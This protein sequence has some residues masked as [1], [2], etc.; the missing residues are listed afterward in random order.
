M[1]DSSTCDSNFEKLS[2]RKYLIGP[3]TFMHLFGF[4][5]FSATAT[6]YYPYNVGKSLFSNSSTENG[7]SSVCSSNLNASETEHSK[8]IQSEVAM[9]LM[10]LAVCEG[11]PCI[12]SNLLLGSISDR[13]GRKKMLI[14][15]TIGLLFAEV[16]MII[17][18][19]FEFKLYY[20]LIPLILH[21]F[22][23]EAFAN[24][25]FAL[26]YTSDITGNNKKR[27]VAMGFMEIFIGM[28]LLVGGVVA[29]YVIRDGGYLW[30]MIT[31]FPITLSNIILICLLPETRKRKIKEPWHCM[32]VLRSLHK[33]LQFYYSKNY[34]GMR[35]KYNICIS[36]CVIG[37]MT[38]IGRNQTEVLYIISPPFCLS[39]VNVG[40]FHA[41]R[42]VM[43]HGIS[44]ILIRV[45][46]ICLRAETIAVLGAVSGTISFIAEGLTSSTVVLFLTPV[47]GLGMS[48]GIVMMRSIMSRETP[49]ESQ[50][51]L[52]GGMAAVQTA[53]TFFGSLIFS[54]LYRNTVY[55]FQGTVFLLMAAMFSISLVLSLSLTFIPK[56]RRIEYD[57]E[58]KEN[59]TELNEKF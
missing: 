45:F 6:L 18:M 58:V 20:L 1:E 51:A 54:A 56:L 10:Y 26:S 9:F 7:K 49:N 55:Y 36:I 35:L 8:I 39:T 38:I 5:I 29:G 50:G 16:L 23:G 52:F 41:I 17:F 47:I 37:F 53:C 2:G 3:I 14:I 24:I 44:M 13:V 22:S 42:G 43:Q 19:Y 57:L 28:G 12:L 59:K 25:Q 15:P 30:S 32:N 34:S 21:G 4:S 46:V 48:L 31:A 33:S 40:W 11:I 27:T